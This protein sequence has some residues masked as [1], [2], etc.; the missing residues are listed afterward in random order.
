VNG[1]AEFFNPQLTDAT[2]EPTDYKVTNFERE[3]EGKIKI[4]EDLAE[5]ERPRLMNV[6]K[7][8]NTHF[9]K[10]PGKCNAFRYSFQLKEGI[11]KSR[12]SRPIPF[13]LKKEVRTQIKEMLRDVPSNY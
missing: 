8:F 11:P 2:K 4:A 9:T 1:E 3:F 13:A 5:N 7:R 12:S 10:T 6:L